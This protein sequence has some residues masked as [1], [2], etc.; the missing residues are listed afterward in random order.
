MS[1]WTPD[2]AH[3]QTY[4]STRL[5]PFGGPVIYVADVEYKQGEL[6]DLTDDPWAKVS[7]QFG[8]D[9]ADYD[10]PA[11]QDYQLI[12]DL[13]QV[14]IANGLTWVAFPDNNGTT[15][16]YLAQTMIPARPTVVR[17]T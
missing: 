3:A 15:W 5:R 10:Y 4:T 9:R 12:A 13:R 8:I 14:L 11:W 6:L 1:N 16:L 17:A 7:E 2:L